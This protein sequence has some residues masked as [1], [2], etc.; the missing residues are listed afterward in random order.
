MLPGKLL[1]F[2]DLHVV[3]IRNWPTLTRWQETQ[4]FPKGR[5]LG[6]NTRVWTEEEV[7][8]WWESR[9][10]PPPEIRSGGPVSPGTAARK[11]KPPSSPTR[12]SESP[13]PAQAFPNGRAGA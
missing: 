8:A 4:G 10:E 6:E 1:R 7:E 5:L 3:G 2:K 11:P 12:I 13:E 9:A